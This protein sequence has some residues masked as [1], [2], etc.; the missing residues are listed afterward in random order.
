MSSAP[1]MLPV[2]WPQKHSFPGWLQELSRM[3]DRT[4]SGGESAGLGHGWGGVGV[5]D[6]IKAIQAYR[7]YK[8]MF[9]P[10]FLLT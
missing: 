7:H 6:V 2:H 1:F 8:E 9:F 10:L 4:A 5:G 3:H